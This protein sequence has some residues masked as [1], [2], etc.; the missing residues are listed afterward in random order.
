MIRTL[1]TRPEALLAGTFAGLILMGTG[2]LALPIAHGGAHVSALDAF[3]TATS[4]TC[5]TGLVTVDTATAYSRFGQTVILVLFQFGGLGLMTFGT[6]AAQ[7]FRL[8]MSFRSQAAWASTFFDRSVRWNLRR[9]VFHIVALTVVFE[10]GGALV[11]ALTMPGDAEHPAGVFEAVFLAVSAF[12]NAGFSV[13]SDSAVG[14]RESGPALVTLMVLIVAGGLGYAVW[15]EMLG[16]LARYIRQGERPVV[17]S[18]QTR[19]VMRMSLIL[20]AGGALVLFVVGVGGGSGGVVGRIWDALFQS[21]TART[22]GFNTVDIGALPLAALLILTALM[23]VGGSPGSCAGGVKTTTVAVWLARVRARLTGHEDVELWGRRLPHEIVRRAALVLALAL[24]WNVVGVM[25]LCLT[26]RG[27][28]ALRLEDLVFE[29]VSAFATVG[30]ST[31]VTPTLSML[32][33]LW[34]VAS[35]FVGRLGP[36]TVA[37]AVL[38]PPRTTY[39]YPSERVMVG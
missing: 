14:L 26:E 31:G 23:L 17:W 37:L 13:Y 27:M 20:V 9:A 39:R 24:L 18:L 35:M 38:P 6:F 32:G 2:L 3:F 5:V 21:I 36:L 10:L 8:R 28:G 34:I 25:V 29:Q 12:C 7:A 33:K 16:R 22:A 30:L 11:L 19:I 4:A 1:L 15:L